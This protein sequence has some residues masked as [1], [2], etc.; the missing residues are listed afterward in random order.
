MTDLATRKAWG[1]PERPANAEQPIPM[2][3]TAEGKLLAIVTTPWSAEQ[4]A[5][6][7]HREAERQRWIGPPIEHPIVAA[8]RQVEADAERDQMPGMMSCSPRRPMTIWRAQCREPRR[9]R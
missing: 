5:A 8:R 9:P 4:V 3:P 7:N 2:M 1:T 6:W